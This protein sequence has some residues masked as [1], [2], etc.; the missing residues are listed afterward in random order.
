MLHVR[1]RL[2]PSACLP[3]CLSISVAIKAYTLPSGGTCCCARC[4]VKRTCC[5][6]QWVIRLRFFGANVLLAEY[7]RRGFQSSSGVAREQ[8]FLSIS[9][10]LVERRTLLPCWCYCTVVLERDVLLTF[11]LVY[12]RFQVV[13]V[14]LVMFTLVYAFYALYIFA[15]FAVNKHY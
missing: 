1:G 11:R 6:R 15:I 14:L 12:S 10:I 5:L 3:V 4:R 7:R 9:N 13:L 2:S 8:R